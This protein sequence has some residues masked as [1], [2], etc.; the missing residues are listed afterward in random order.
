MVLKLSTLALAELPLEDLLELNDYSIVQ[1]KESYNILVDRLNLPQAEASYIK[2]TYTQQQFLDLLRFIWKNEAV[3][4]NLGDWQT[5]IW[6]KIPNGYFLDM[7][8]SNRVML[9]TLEDLFKTILELY[10][11]QPTIIVESAGKPKA[12]NINGILQY[13]IIEKSEKI[14]K[15]KQILDADGIIIVNNKDSDIFI[16]PYHEVFNLTLLKNTK[17]NSIKIMGVMSIENDRNCLEEKIYTRTYFDQKK[18]EQL[19]AYV[20]YT[21]YE[22]FK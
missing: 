12:T 16:S 5:I 21:E 4:L 2:S 19:L 20:A 8:Y 14:K 7:G 10:L 6:K 17:E 22:E 11:A 18:I 15:L 13:M 9:D 3:F 1:S